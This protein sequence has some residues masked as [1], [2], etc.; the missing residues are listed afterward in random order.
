MV[1]TDLLQPTQIFLPLTQEFQPSARPP[2]LTQ[3]FSKGV[4]G[5]PESWSLEV[6]ML[7]CD[8]VTVESAV[9]NS[10]ALNK[11]EI[12][13]CQPTNVYCCII[14]LFLARMNNLLGIFTIFTWSVCQARPVFL[15]L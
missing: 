9:K 5:L 11:Q 1:R 6:L 13:I 15:F 3:G 2:P 10:P 8:H 12:I 7:E 14:L 4:L